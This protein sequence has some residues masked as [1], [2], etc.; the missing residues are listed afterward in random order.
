MFKCCFS[1]SD[2]YVVHFG[3][4]SGRSRS[5]YASLESSSL[6]ISPIK[7]LQVLFQV[8]ISQNHHQQAKLKI[9]HLKMHQ[10]F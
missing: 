6:L 1:Y 9:V 3:H 10:V 5:V 2:T 8:R 7:F 4:S